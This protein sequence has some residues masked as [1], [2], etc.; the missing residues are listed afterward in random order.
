MLRRIQR[1]YRASQHRYGSPK[2]H[3]ALRDEGVRVGEKR[4]ARLMREAGLKARVE[5]V[6]RRMKNR[7]ALLKDLPNHRLDLPRRRKVTTLAQ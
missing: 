6:Y 7:R 5:W 1:I 3:R 4:V 2:I